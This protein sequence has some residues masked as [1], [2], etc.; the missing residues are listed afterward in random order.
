MEW[1]QTIYRST[2]FREFEY[3]EFQQIL[4]GFSGTVRT[5]RKATTL[6]NEGDLVSWGGIVL[7]GSLSAIKTQFDGSISIL[8]IIFPSKVYALDMALTP[9]KV[10][11]L[12]I[13]SLEDSTVF[14]FPFTGMETLDWMKDSHKIRMAGNIL[15]YLANENV[16][17][18]HKIEITSQHSIRKRVLTYLYFMSEQNGSR[19][20]TIPY[21]REQLAN[22]LCV[23]R[24]ALSHELS[25]LRREGILTCRKNRF[26]LLKSIK[27]QN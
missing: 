10:S 4:P 1:M 26:T 6:L 2:L 16:R 12:S 5:V 18:Q 22:Y 14:T 24:S 8:D 21:S 9:S 25:C 20:F 7:K 15:T 3:D 17:K 13:H 19:S 11:A 23:N 27:E